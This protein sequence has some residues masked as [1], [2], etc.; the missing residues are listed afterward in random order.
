VNASGKR[1]PRPRQPS[2]AKDEFLATLSP[3]L[4]TP[5]AAMVGWTRM[6]RNGQP[7]AGKIAQGAG[8]HR[9]QR[10]AQAT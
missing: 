1:A 2:R 7:D 10:K 4:R 5:L 6:L 9:A 8:D 3:E